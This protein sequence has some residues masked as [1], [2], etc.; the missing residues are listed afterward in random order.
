LR[1]TQPKTEIKGTSWFDTLYFRRFSQ[2]MKKIKLKILCVLT[3]GSLIFSSEANAFTDG[4]F[5][6]GAG[7]YQ[8]N[9]LGKTTKSEDAS[10]SLTG[11][12]SYPLYIK[13]DW[14]MTSEWYLSPQLLY[15]PVG[16]DSAGGATTTTLLQ[17]ALPVGF[18]LYRWTETKLDWQTG[19]GIN[20]YSTKGNGGTDT[21]LNGSTPTVF[22]RPSRTTAATT[23]VFLLGSSL[24]YGSSRVTFDFVFEGLLSEKRTPSV[25]LGYLYGL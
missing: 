5:Q 16:R 23:A 8:Q 19:I 11:A 15:T 1:F 13:Y 9:A 22:Q 6:V 10:A 17:I 4:S 7:L 25:M 3:G 14:L 2:R 21:L 18:D 12:F 20:Q 24:S